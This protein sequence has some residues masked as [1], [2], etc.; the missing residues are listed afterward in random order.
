MESVEA[1]AVENGAVFAALPPGGIAIFPDDACTP[2]WRQLNG[3]RT[4]LPISLRS[5]NINSKTKSLK[6]PEQLN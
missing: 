6:C 3:D 4:E 1:T 5:E 2:I